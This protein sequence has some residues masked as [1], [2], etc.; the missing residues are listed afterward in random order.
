MDP[1]QDRPLVDKL[2]KKN[3]L[4]IDDDGIITKTLCDLLNRSGFY[5]DASQD[6][7]DA[8]DK[9]DDLDFD[10]VIS[11]IKMPEMDGI[12]T[13]RKI[14]EAAR[15]KNKPDVPVIFITGY[16]QSETTEEAR[17]LGEV[18]FKPFDNKEFLEKISK[19]I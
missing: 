9:T 13:V 7:F 14:R 5:A 15:A 1:H 17:E 8:I 16:V 18:I 11:D 6:G 19:Y 3:I 4:I 12:E 10:L 2:A